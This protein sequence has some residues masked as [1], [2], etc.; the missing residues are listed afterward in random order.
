VDGPPEVCPAVSFLFPLNLLERIGKERNGG[1]PLVLFGIP[2][3]ST[4]EHNFLM[5]FHRF[6]AT[7]LFR[8][9]RACMCPW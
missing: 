4:V 9:L 2:L 1:T 8:S 7:F 6:F 3:V 5:F